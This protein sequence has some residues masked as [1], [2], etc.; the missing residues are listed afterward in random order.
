[1]LKNI[2]HIIK[3]EMINIK[4]IYEYNSCPICFLEFKSAKQLEAH[5]LYEHAFKGI[6]KPDIEV[7][8]IHRGDY[9]P[10]CFLEFENTEQL[11]MHIVEKHSRFKLIKTREAQI[12]QCLECGYKWRSKARL[13]FR[14]PKC[15]NL[16]I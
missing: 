10:I 4:T 1:M 11:R 6:K 13:R 12:V 5:F 2:I 7:K 3:K 8:T 9:C 14:C 16:W 15:N